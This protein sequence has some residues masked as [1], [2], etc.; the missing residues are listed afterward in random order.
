MML[1]PKNSN[2]FIKERD[3]RI[4]TTSARAHFQH[5]VRL[6]GMCYGYIVHAIE[7]SVSVRPVHGTEPPSVE[8]AMCSQNMECPVH[9]AGVTVL[10]LLTGLLLRL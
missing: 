6:D 4:D 5:V 1:I 10:N 9:E 3:H 2:F 8:L 7:D